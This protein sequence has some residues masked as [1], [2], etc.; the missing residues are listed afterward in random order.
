MNDTEQGINLD[1]MNIDELWEFWTKANSVRPISLARELFPAK[2][3]NYVRVTK[4]LGDYA[5]N[6]ATAMKCRLDGSIQ[7]A[8]MYESIAD[9]IYKQ[10]PEWAK[11]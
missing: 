6:K 7:T 3:R 11:W 5:A 2:P 1:G 8:L 9:R 10:L 4:D